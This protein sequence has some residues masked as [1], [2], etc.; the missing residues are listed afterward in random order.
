[1]TDIQLL[2]PTTLAKVSQLEAEWNELVGRIGWPQ[3]DTPDTA[4]AEVK[5]FRKK[6]GVEYKATSEARLAVTREYD[7]LKSALI[8]EEKKL[9]EGAPDSPASKAKLWE[10]N[11]VETR[12]IADRKKQEEADK[13]IARAAAGPRF[14]EGVSKAI[15]DYLY[16]L[17]IA[18]DL[19]LNTDTDM[20]SLELDLGRPIVLLP[21]KYKELANTVAIPMM[22]ADPEVKDT[23]LA[24]NAGFKEELMNTFREQMSVFQRDLLTQI[25]ARRAQI[26]AGIAGIAS[27]A[28]LEAEKEAAQER[29][30]NVAVQEANVATIEATIDNA[31]VTTAA[32][33]EYDPT[34]R[35]DWVK[36]VAYALAGPES[37][38]GLTAE[39]FA[40]NMNKVVTYANRK[41]KAGETIAVKTKEVIK[42][43]R[44]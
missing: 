6:W 36:L 11:L 22:A 27:T 16:G 28:A 14:K 35:E 32:L 41:L 42:A 26:A 44:K 30:A 24:A 7:A 23:I 3:A 31:V 17:K 34:T 39:W 2:Q 9:D 12:R 43:S 10:V 21:E 40:K 1:M 37:E 13:V 20:D 18:L 29:I 15:N 4:L 8:V 33:V 25:P 38:T 19:R 5:A